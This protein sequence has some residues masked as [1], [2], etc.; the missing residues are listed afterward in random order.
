MVALALL[1]NT[2]PSQLS[3]EL[4]KCGYKVYE[5]VSFSDI[6]HLCDYL[7]PAAVVIAC[8][9]DVDAIGDL[10]RRHIVIEQHVGCTAEKIVSTLRTMFGDPTP[11][12]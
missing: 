11:K 5:A 12:Q 4:E 3:L 1:S 6:V 8:D 2:S 7:E 10:A 9:V